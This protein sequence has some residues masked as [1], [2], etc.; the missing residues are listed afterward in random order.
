M[1]TWYI[2]DG[3]INYEKILKVHQTLQGPYVTCPLYDALD[4]LKDVSLY[5]ITTFGCIFLDDNIE[6]AKSWKGK[7]RSSLCSQASMISVA[8]G[9]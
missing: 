4:E 3:H 6:M 5:L 7:K 9:F 8:N 2:K 1:K